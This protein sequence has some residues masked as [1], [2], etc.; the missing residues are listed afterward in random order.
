MDV[1]NHHH[2][3]EDA[4]TASPAKKSRGAGKGG[5]RLRRLKLRYATTSR[6]QVSL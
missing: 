2:D 4:L 3:L 6:A 5:K 1:D